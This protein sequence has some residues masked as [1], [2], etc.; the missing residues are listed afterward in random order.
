VWF[1]F[2]DTSAPPPPPTAANTPTLAPSI[3]GASLYEVCE[4]RSGEL[5]I[6]RNSLPGEFEENV[7]KCL[8]APCVVNVENMQAYGMLM[9]AC[10]EAGGAFHVYSLN[11]SCSQASFKFNNY[12]GC[13]I[14]QKVNSV[15]D[16]VR[17]EELLENA[18][19]FDGCDEVATHTGTTDFYH[20]ARPGG[21]GNLT[22]P[23]APPG[24][25]PSSS[26]NTAPS[27]SAT[28]FTLEDAVGEP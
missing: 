27:N 1:Y 11:V 8:S 15:C 3:S 2:Q 28:N 7:N 25:A 16:P 17:F 22:I 4:K 24:R 13:A 19:D 20:D 18:L 10:E 6:A 14:S 21:S 12:P 26:T 23:A 9:G 5:L